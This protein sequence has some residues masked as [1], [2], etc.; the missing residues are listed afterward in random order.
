[1]TTYNYSLS[2][3]NK[4]LMSKAVGLSLPIST[5][6]SIEVC[7]FIRYRKLAEAKKI[8]A[9]VVEE[10]QAVPIKRFN[11]ELAH[12]RAI[13]PGRYPITVAAEILKILKS[14]ESNAQLQGLSTSN[15]VVKHIRA[16][17]ASRPWKAG[18]H[19]GRLAKR[20]HIEVVLEEVKA[21]KTQKSET[22]KKK[23]L[24]DTDVNKSGVKK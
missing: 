16:N 14:A 23:R 24:K 5:K 18:R 3:F 8:L 21:E 17:R 19:R 13:G 1:M 6:I 9:N 20:T 15:L 7:N 12:R 4:E 11:K 22:S 10:K 2:N